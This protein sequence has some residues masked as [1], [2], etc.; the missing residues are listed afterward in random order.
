MGGLV[1][2]G[3][4]EVAKAELLGGGFGRTEARMRVNGVEV[5]DCG[6]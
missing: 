6:L 4:C 3:E 1:E 5:F 2:E